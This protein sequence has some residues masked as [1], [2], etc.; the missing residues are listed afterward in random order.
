MKDIN[1][2]LKNII[3]DKAKSGMIKKTMRYIDNLEEKRDRLSQK[4]LS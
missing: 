2:P 4:N 3:L 1:N